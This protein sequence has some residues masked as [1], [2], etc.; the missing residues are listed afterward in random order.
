MCNSAHYPLI[1]CRIVSTGQ[2]GLFKI[3]QNIQQTLL[4]REREVFCAI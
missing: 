3:D 1:N 4:A 2:N